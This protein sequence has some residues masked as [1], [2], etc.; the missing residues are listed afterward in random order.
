MD[1]SASPELTKLIWLA[2]N[3]ETWSPVYG[4]YEQT[5]IQMKND[6]IVKYFHLSLFFGFNPLKLTLGSFRAKAESRS[7]KTKPK[8]AIELM[9]PNE[10][11]TIH[12]I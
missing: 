9:E 11:K 12:W 4:C 3:S 1:Q 10:L 8:P 2:G 7:Y 6:D 5:C